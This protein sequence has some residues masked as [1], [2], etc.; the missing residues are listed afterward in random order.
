MLRLAIGSND[1]FELSTWELDRT[2]I[3]Y[4]IDTLEHLRAELPDADLVLLIGGDSA[5]DFHTWHR[6]AEIAALARVAVWAR[7]GAELPRE[8][9][10]GV[11]YRT[12]PSPLIE[13]SSTGIRERRARGG[14]IRY[15][16]PDSV[17]DYI[18]THALYIR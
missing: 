1:R 9:I 14:S 10:P 3:S 11:G 16:T 12:I 5:R 17:V 6:P 13:I 18:I 7:P 4:T 8:I 2:G 15:L